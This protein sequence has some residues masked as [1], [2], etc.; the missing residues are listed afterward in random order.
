MGL[1]PESMETD[2]LVCI[3]SDAR[4]PFV[5][6]KCSGDSDKEYRLVGEAYVHG[7]MQGEALKQADYKWE[8]ICLI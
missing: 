1:G 3:I 6:R 5:I 4:T 7:M 8:D 2:D